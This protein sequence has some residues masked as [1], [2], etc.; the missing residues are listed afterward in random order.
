MLNKKNKIVFVVGFPRSGTTWFSNLL[1]A[2]P[3]VI[4]RH[5]IV[6]RCYEIFGDE[7]FN[8][9]KFNHGLSAEQHH[10]F[11]KQLA[12]A[13]VETDRPPFFNKTV[14]KV[15]SES[16]HKTAWLATKSV[17]L[18]NSLYQYL[19]T[20]DPKKNTTFLLKETR[21]TINLDSIIKGVAPSSILFL[22]REPYGA[23]ASHIK[24]L[25][26]KT[27]GGLSKKSNDTWL[28]GHAQRSY[29]KALI[30]NG[31]DFNTASLVEI[32]AIKW[33]VYNDD[34]LEM[35]KTFNQAIFCHYDEFV[36]SPTE[37][38][39]Q[40]FNNINLG[41]VPAVAEFIAA[42][43]NKGKNQ[44]ILQKDASNDF[45]SVY[46]PA[47]FNKEQWREILSAE[48]INIIDKHTKSTFEL[49]VKACN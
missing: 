47:G 30:E 11:L 46:R 28:Q 42:S 37:L 38:T 2:H 9:L 43:G 8:N 36:Q 23:I 4:Y 7:L 18:L 13:N 3:E 19:F 5:E 34:L 44:N 41:F 24:G 16:L 12:L 32:L 45:F 22:F 6:G 48:D 40:L 27:M 29:V 14:L 21:S 33:R 1:N 35:R 25:K 17:P 10:T 39:T 49:L 15:A 31:F 20:P 26:L